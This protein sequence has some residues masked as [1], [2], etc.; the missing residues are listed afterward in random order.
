MDHNYNIILNV[1]EKLRIMT[2]RNFATDHSRHF[3]VL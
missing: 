2:R 3:W 1:G